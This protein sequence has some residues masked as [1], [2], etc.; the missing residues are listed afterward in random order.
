MK[1][2]KKN[3]LRR[4]EVFVCHERRMVGGPMTV[5]GYCKP[6][7]FNKLKKGDIFRC[8]DT[9]DDGNEKPDQI[10][11]GQ[12]AVQVALE[13]TRPKP[14]PMLGVVECLPVRGF[15]KGE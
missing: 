14:M 7:H 9:D 5:D 3:P 15:T 6:I 8:F 2:T 4:T 10:I 1:P 11:K 12:H 13:N